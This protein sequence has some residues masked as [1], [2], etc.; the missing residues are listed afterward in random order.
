MY[1]PEIKWRAPGNYPSFKVV[2]DALQAAIAANPVQAMKNNW[3][4]DRNGVETWVDSYNASI[5]VA[6]G[7]DDYVVSS[8]A[9]T[10]PKWS[11]PHQ[12]Q[13]LQSLQSAVAKSKELVAGAKTLIEWLDA[14]EKPVDRDL[15]TSR[16]KT[17]SECPKNES[18][19]WTRLFTVPAAE[20]IRRQVAKAQEMAMSTI[21]DEKLHLCSACACPLKLKVH[22]PISWITKRL[23]EEQK[24]R[25]DQSCWI[26]KEVM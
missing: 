26:P 20:L 5:C 3:P 1:V 14:G 6:M 10:L 9:Q 19:D 17:C 13:T 12:Q 11:P 4:Q 7:W 2:C 23:T 18:G 25:L 16:A 21:Y 8:A 15:A 24:V 22:V